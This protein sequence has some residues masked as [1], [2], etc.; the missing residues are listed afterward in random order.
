LDI[1]LQLLSIGSESSCGEN[2]GKSG[3]VVVQLPSALASLLS[4]LAKSGQIETLVFDG[5]GELSTAL[6]DRR[7]E[8]GVWVLVRLLY[9]PLPLRGMLVSV[10][11][12][13][14]QESPERGKYE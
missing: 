7:L 4:S 8:P 11:D 2:T 14:P 10:V 5:V 1:G 13:L 6:D 12:H 3:R 9:Q